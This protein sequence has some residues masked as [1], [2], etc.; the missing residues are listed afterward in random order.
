MGVGIPKL[1]QH[2][3]NA[4][5]SIISHTRFIKHYG[6]NVLL[7]NSLYIKSDLCILLL[8]RCKMMFMVSGPTSCD[9][10]EIH[11]GANLCNSIS[12]IHVYNCY[13]NFKNYL[14]IV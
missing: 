11:F 4:T 10:E 13:N 9:G 5:M 8:D 6:N 14:I 12:S 3:T 7:Q 2:R 1:D